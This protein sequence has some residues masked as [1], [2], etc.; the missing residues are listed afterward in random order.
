MNCR[1]YAAE[2]L[3]KIWINAFYESSEVTDEENFEN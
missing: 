1:L 3:S 2:K